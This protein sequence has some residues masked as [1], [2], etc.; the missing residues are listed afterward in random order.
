M[1]KNVQKQHFLLESMYHISN[2]MNL[3]KIAEAY[4]HDIPVTCQVIR[5]DTE[6]NFLEVYLGGNIY[7]TIPLEESSIYS[8]TKDGKIAS[9]IFALV[10]CNVR[11]YI[12]SVKNGIVLSRKMHM[13]DALNSIYKIK[14]FKYASITGF[15]TLTAFVDVGAG[16]LGK[17]S[18]NNFAPVIY[19]NIK[20]I[21]FEKNYIIS[22][23]V[24]DYDPYNYRFELSRLS[25]LP[26]FSEVFHKG[27]LVECKIFG[28]LNDL[29]GYYVC[30][31][32]YVCGIMDAPDFPLSYNEK[33]VACVSHV[34]QAFKPGL[35]LKFVGLCT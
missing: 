29:S 13:E 26:H 11:A 7:G 9:K 20:D 21:G 4:L 23:D 22:V 27:D 3:R 35:Q 6:N 25:C 5:I 28:K 19:R 16:I 17:I 10:G 18:P 32:T 31:N 2:S 12:I 8:T 24:L 33:V 34:P 30:V 15:T 14:H 1:K